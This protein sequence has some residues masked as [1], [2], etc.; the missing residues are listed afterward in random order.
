MD[1]S[2]QHN[3]EQIAK[4]LSGNMSPVELARFQDWLEEHPANRQML[5]EALGVWQLGEEETI[6]DFDKDMDMAWT[7]VEQHIQ[8]E[9]IGTTRKLK[10]S[11]RSWAP[12]IA[13]SLA[14]IILAAW[15]LMQWRQGDAEMVAYS[16]G[17]NETL[18]IVL[19]DSST[20]WLNERSTLRRP[21]DFSQRNIQLQG[22]AFFQIRRMEHSPFR[23]ESGAAM[24]EVLGTSFNVRAY[25]EEEKVELTVV[26]GQVA[27][28]RAGAPK[29]RLLVEAGASAVLDEKQETELQAEEKISNAES[30]HTG[31]LLFEDATLEM[32]RLSFERFYGI[33]L[34]VD[35]PA[36]WNCHFTGSFDKAPAAELAHTIAFSLNLEL[37]QSDSV[38]TLS[39]KG[40][41]SQ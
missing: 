9:P 41:E 2:T 21:A 10:V 18:S 7:K 17:P 20:V 22:E 11:F 19:P 6:P 40:C 33:R 28:S 29:T 5:Q 3:L 4:F 8:R 26:T 27:F 30:W 24:T 39:G 25:P 32:V 38:F 12:R 37:Q 14:F 36:I 13:A 1:L 15:A 16:T 35:D 34:E 31:K 23:I